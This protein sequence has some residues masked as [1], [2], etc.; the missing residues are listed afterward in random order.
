MTQDDQIID[1]VVILCS[2]ITAFFGIMQVI[3]H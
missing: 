1:A 3:G 2:L